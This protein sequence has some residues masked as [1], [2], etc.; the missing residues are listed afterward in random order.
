M[1][2]PE[3]MEAIENTLGTIEETAATLERIPKVNLNG[4]TKKQQIIILGTVAAVSAIAGAGTTYALLKGKIHLRRKK[5]KKIIK[6]FEE[7]LADPKK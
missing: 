6:D 1:P 5:N 3:T 2:K 4:T 7:K